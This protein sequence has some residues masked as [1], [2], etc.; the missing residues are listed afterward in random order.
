M[1]HS[2]IFV[3][4][5][6]HIIK[7]A[8]KEKKPTIPT[9]IIESNK[10]VTVI[11]GCGITGFGGIG[12]HLP[13]EQRPSVIGFETKEVDHTF[14]CVFGYDDIARIKIDGQL[15]WVNRIYPDAPNQRQDIRQTGITEIEFF[16]KKVTKEFIKR[17]SASFNILGF[18]P[19]IEDE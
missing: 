11:A 13:Q 1:L 19:T 12:I 2:S 5:F 15:V 16:D 9:F 6:R 4:D 3:A 8:E 14:G 17:N 10:E 7:M 18:T